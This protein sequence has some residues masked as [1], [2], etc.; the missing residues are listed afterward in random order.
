MTDYINL[1]TKAATGDSALGKALYED[2]GATGGQCITC[3]GADG[4]TILFHDGVDGVGNLALDNPWEI[5]HKIRFGHPGSAMPSTV[6]KDL[7]TQNAVD[8]LTH[9][10]TLPLQ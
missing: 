3:H 4:R 9:T 2:T 1:T 6:D 8:I 5:L 7:T 10:Q